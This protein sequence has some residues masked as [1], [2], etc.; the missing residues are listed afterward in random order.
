MPSGITHI[1]LVK[2]FNEESRHGNNEL[3]LLL[4]E[5]L[6]V[7]QVGALAPDLAY[8]QQL[9]NRD[10][11]SDEDEFSDLFHY[12]K[13]SDI[14]LGAFK[15]IKN[16]GDQEAKDTNFAFFLGYAA[17][18]VADGIVHPFVRDKVGNYDDASGPH[19]AL[20]MRLDGIFLDYLSSK[21]GQ[22]IDVNFAELHDQIKDVRKPE[23]KKI[24][25]LFSKLIKDVYNKNLKPVEIEDWI[26]D[27]HDIFEIAA[28]KNNCYYARFPGASSYLYNDTSKVLANRDRDL[29]LRN[30]DVVG[31]S[32]TFLGKDV[33]FL[34]DCIPQFYKA[35]SKVALSAY[36]YVYENGPAIDAN[37]LSAINLDT[38]RTLATAKGKNLDM[39]AFYW[40]V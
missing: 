10:L 18:L 32:K 31:R 22:S 37:L 17:H 2:T 11:F 39:P 1:L 24:S 20:E 33:H 27:L 29:W 4:D 16:I 19:R 9:P 40:S 23:L 12:D 13:T 38:G 35:F 15:A 5:K 21:N 3:E 8:S 26:D 25:S 34:N 30:G 28:S 6:K 7:F 36:S 14:P